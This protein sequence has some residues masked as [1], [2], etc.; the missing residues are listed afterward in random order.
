MIKTGIE[1]GVLGCGLV[2]PTSGIVITKKIYT[3]YSDFDAKV[4]LYTSTASGNQNKESIY[5]LVRDLKIA[6]IW[7]RCIAIYPFIGGTATTFRPNLMSSTQ[8]PLTFNGGATF[9]RTGYLPNG[10]SGF[11]NTGINAN[12]RLTQSNTHLA[13]YSRTSA[14]AEDRVSMGAIVGSSSPMVGIQFRNAAGN[15]VAQNAS[16]T[17][18]QTAV[19]ANSNSS[20]FFIGNKTSAAI[21]GL[22][23]IRN[24]V[25][26][27]S[28]TATITVNNFPNANIL[29]GAYTATTF[30]DN[31][32]C[33][34]ASVGLG[35]TA[36]QIADYTAIVNNF[37]IIQERNV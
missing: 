23:M 3:R 22:S 31:K 16:G 17:A 1:T 37:Q 4:F 12:A 14:A 25:T 9:S 2:R 6:G 13:F 30:F 36:T 10:T 34:F 29:I 15:A 18:N 19:T 28:N 8:Y 11:A 20:G 27:A 5:T 33:A 24:G 21:G 32:E 26:L 7:D 35:L